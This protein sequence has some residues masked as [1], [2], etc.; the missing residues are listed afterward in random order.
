[1]FYTITN[2]EYSATISNL[3]AELK[4]FRNKILRDEYIWEG[5]PEIWNGSAP[6]LF[7]IIGRLKNENY[8]F[9]DKSYQLNK[10]GFARNAVFE[11]NQN[12]ESEKSFILRS[13]STTESCYPFKFELEVSFRIESESLQVAYLVRNLGNEMMYFT[14][15]SHPAFALPLN[16]C[17]LEDYYLEFE[18]EE[19]LDCFYLENE[20]LCEEPIALYLNNEKII[21]ITKNLFNKD[22]LIFKNIKSQKVSIKNK[23][24][25]NRLLLNTGK[26]PHLAI[27][28]KAGAPF[29]CL[30]PWY[31]YDDS[32]SS[33]NELT[34]KYGIM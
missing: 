17:V 21:P 26:A 4:S 14:L 7:P 1:M 5:D 10:H 34:K 31:S 25:G 23:K 32:I 13:S 28:A 18:L 22:A 33:D 6:I 9:H 12:Q 24:S 15:G 27:W 8:I 29:V 16:D 3:G 30:E 11:L 19:R 2:N 20:L